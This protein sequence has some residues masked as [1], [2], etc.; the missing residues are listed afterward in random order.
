MSPFTH[1]LVVLLLPAASPSSLTQQPHPAASPSSLTQQ[2]HP[3]AS[4][5]SLTQQPHP[6]ASPSSLTQQPHPAASPSSLTQHSMLLG[7]DPAAVG[8][9]YRMKSTATTAWSCEHLELIY[10]DS[11][12]STWRSRSREHV[13]PKSPRVRVACHHMYLSSQ[14]RPSPS[15]R[16]Y[17]HLTS[18]SK[19]K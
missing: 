10:G 13:S 1:S 15:S 7:E 12:Q 17:Q 9:M 14:R 8:Y 19:L 2:P 4:P 3:A 11:S 6:A 16:Q 18:P 5:S